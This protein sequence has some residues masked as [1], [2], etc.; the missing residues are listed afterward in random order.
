MQLLFSDLL[1]ILA[2]IDR[3]IWGWD[4]LSSLPNRS[5]ML[6][7]PDLLPYLL[8]TSVCTLVPTLLHDV[9][10]CV[11]YSR[12]VN[13]TTSQA[14]ELEQRKARCNTKSHSKKH[15]KEVASHST[16]RS[17]TTPAAQVKVNRRVLEQGL[18]EKT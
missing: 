3:E 14:Q 17:P 10:S 13:F 18:Y 4:F 12:S 16:K 9:L 1:L 7:N 5:P 8:R 15:K 11:P 2:K 6:R